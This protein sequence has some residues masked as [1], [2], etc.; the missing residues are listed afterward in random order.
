[1]L[2]EYRT[3]NNWWLSKGERDQ[4]WVLKGP[5]GT[6]Y[7]LS[8]KA[9]DQRRVISSAASADVFGHSEHPLD[10]SHF[11]TLGGTFDYYMPSTAVDTNG[12]RV[13]YRY[14]GVLLT[15]MIASDGRTINI[16]WSDEG[17]NG[18]RWPKLDR[19][20]AAG[21]EWRFLDSAGQVVITRPDGLRWVLTY[22][23][24]SDYMKGKKE[25]ASAF[26]LINSVAQPQ[27]GKTYFD[28]VRYVTP[29]SPFPDC[30]YTNCADEMWNAIR[31]QPR[32]AI[33]R[34][35]T[36]DGGTWTYHHY[37][38]QGIDGVFA[39]VK[40]PQGQT[41]INLGVRNPER[42]VTTPAAIIS[43]QYIT[44]HAVEDCKND[45][46]KSGLL[47]SKKTADLNGKALETIS[48][49]WGYQT[50]GQSPSKLNARCTSGISRIPLMTGQTVERNG[51]LFNTAYAGYDSYGRAGVITETGD[52]GNTRVTKRTYL[53][54]ATRW[55]LDK[56]Q[57]ETIHASEAGPALST[58]S[59]GYDALGNLLSE[60]RDGVT[61]SYTYHADGQVATVKDPRLFVTQF[62][63]YYRGIPQT[64][65]RPVAAG[66]NT[67]S[68]PT[69]SDITIS[70]VV[71]AFGN[72]TSYTNG[73]R[74]AT[75]LQYDAM[76]R[77]TTIT[78]PAGASTTIVWS[79]NGRTLTR[80]TYSD[81]TT[82]DGFGR[83]IS[84]TINGVTITRRFDAL[85]RQTFESYPQLSVGDTTYY[86]AL[87]R[88]TQVTH[89]DGT[90]RTY[91]YS[92]SAVAEVNER[93]YQTSSFYQAFGSPDDKA[94]IKVVPP[95]AEAI[96]EIDRDILGKVNWVK[97]NGVTRSW[98]Y[99]SRQYLVSRTDPET[100]TT[101]LG[102]DNAGN[103]ISSKT[104]SQGQINYGYDA[105]NRLTTVEYADGSAE[106]ACRTYDGD[107]NLTVLNTPSVQRSMWF[108]NN[109]NM[110][111]ES[112]VAAGRTLTLKH[113][114]NANDARSAM[115]YPGD[116][117]VD[118]APDA[119]GRPTRLGNAVATIQYTA[120]GQLANWLGANG[121]WDKTN[122]NER[123]W[124]ATH[125]VLMS[126]G[127]QGPVKPVPPAA[128]AAPGNAPIAPTQPTAPGFAEP[129]GV[130]AGVFCSEKY[131]KPEL[132]DFG[133]DCNVAEC[134]QSKYA[135]ALKVWR[136]NYDACVADWNTRKNA[137]NNYRAASAAWPGQLATYQQQLA[138]YNARKQAYDRYL[139]DVATYNQA[140]AAYNQAVANAQPVLDSVW[141]YDGNGNVVTIT[142]TVSNSHNRSFDYDGLDRLT[143]A[144]APTVWG[145]GGISYDGNGNIKRQAFGSWSIDYGYD[146]TQNL[147]T[148]TGGKNYTL[149]H[150]GWGNV[151]TRG[152]G[153]S[154]NYD[155]AGNLRWVNKGAA[156][157][158]G[159]SYDGGGTRVLSSGNGLNRLEFT[160]ADGLLY[161]EINLATGAVK[162]F[163]Y[164]GRTKLADI[165]GTTTT[166]YHSDPAGS[167][168]AATGANGALLWR[169][170]YRPYGEKLVG[171]TTENTQ[172]FTG[173][174]FED[175][176]GLSY[177]GA[178]WYDPTLG[179]FM[180]TDPVDWVELNAIHAFNRYGYANSNP[181][182]FVDPD[183]RAP[184]QWQTNR[185]AGLVQSATG[186]PAGDVQHAVNS[187]GQ[188]SGLNDMFASINSAWKGSRTE[189]GAKIEIGAIVTVWAAAHPGYAS[190]SKALASIPADVKSLEGLTATQLTSLQAV[191][192]VAS[193]DLKSDPKTQQVL[194]AALNAI[195]NEVKSREG[196][197]S[198]GKGEEKKAGGES[199]GGGNENQSK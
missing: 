139:A 195:Q 189:F 157:Q 123:G 20:Y 160:G 29:L 93:G 118:L 126:D 65:I 40:H 33:A 38:Q 97:Q 39:A 136:A 5:G 149:A 115:V 188:K 196:K 148:V 127:G 164:H 143:V 177:Y 89:S 190:A 158:I 35:R 174:P 1:M 26:P 57:T 132:Y 125:Q 30:G 72:V 162:D 43:Y 47:L 186:L 88:P 112:L 23:D 51:K 66:L 122:F 70:R 37:A 56:V 191:L 91:G 170:N 69:S 31:D 113:E 167:P 114:Y 110:V 134:A 99:D 80:G 137:W 54:D 169:T 135:A 12:N 104:G 146:A 95:I 98:G 145:N 129:K 155:A 79:T 86:D 193:V 53:T 100:G 25:G 172:W 58:L 16:T 178:R 152:D 21:Q 197:K 50:F 34:K 11:V 7:S 62:S 14:S 44:P 68:C 128:V 15:Q 94:L 181:I 192:A 151:T 108:D 187:L 141:S 9:L 49:N 150:D 67:A 156:S 120:R 17:G 18:K 161:Q 90:Y 198:D 96:T 32:P 166:W 46:W 154:F 168:M 142:D 121:R 76:N 140:L 163:L 173:K 55:I 159:Y 71:D 102:R 130:S 105:Q 8:V 131:R 144:N 41:S 117:R 48:Y 10:A 138:D 45:I 81:S 4:P 179:R 2:G 24:W 183:G 85:G 36:S 42:K 103:Q 28:F 22:S 176:I 63:S 124:P 83:T 78:P 109:D 84:S 27:G 184:Q 153:L 82:W 61:R 73:R 180:A 111:A 101:I 106:S 19:V 59:R 116:R 6:V 199:K 92:G 194:Q 52:T 107:G 64:E 3:S 13:E 77:L 171:A 185:I 87:N 60:T 182:R 165:Q 147:S 119:F 133:S 175:K 75:G 74:F